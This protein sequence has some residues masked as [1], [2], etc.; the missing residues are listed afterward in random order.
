M[1]LIALKKRKLRRE[2]GAAVKD[3][4]HPQKGGDRGKVREGRGESSLY[5]TKL[6]KKFSL[7][8][9]GRKNEVD[10]GGPGAV[11]AP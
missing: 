9:R 3:T 11:W 8:A 5:K 10:R 6:S 2:T 7:H 1:P 4:F